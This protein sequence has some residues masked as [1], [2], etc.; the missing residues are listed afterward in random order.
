METCKIS[1][2]HDHEWVIDLSR[3]LEEDLESHQN[4][5]SFS[6]Y[7]DHDD[8]LAS[9]VSIFNV[10]KALLSCKPE[11]YTPQVIA[12]GPYHHRRLELFE[13][14]RCKITSAKKVQKNMKPGTKFQD[15]VHQISTNDVHTR[16]CYHR[17]L[18]FDQE[19]L[20]WLF[21]I[22]ASFLLEYLQTFCSYSSD[23]YKIDNE[24]STASTRS[25]VMGRHLM[26][27]DY[28][29]RRTVHQEILRDVIMLEN[30]IPLFLIREVHGFFDQQDNIRVHELVL[31]TILMGFCKYISPIKYLEDQNFKQECLTKSHLL[32]LLYDYIV[33]PELQFPQEIIDQEQKEKDT[34]NKEDNEEVTCW[35]ASAIYAIIKLIWLI[36]WAPVHFIIKICKSK[37]AM[38]LITLPLKVL[39]TFFKFRGK[40][41]LT[42]LASSA[43][44]VVEEVENST[45]SVANPEES[46][47]VEELAI[48]S[49]RELSKIGVKFRPTKGGLSTIQFKKSSGI[50]H[51][52]VIHVNDNSDVV[53]RNL[54][55]YEASAAPEAMVFTRYT[56]LMNG[57]IDTEEDVRILREA[58]VLINRMKSDKE[59]ASLWN[60]MTKSVRVTKVPI[61]DRAIKSANEYYLTSWKVKMKAAMKKYVYGSWPWLTFLAANVFLCLTTVEA[62]CS[63][64]QCSKFL[65]VF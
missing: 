41:A 54:V 33:V 31:V 16:A 40:T 61:L 52:P 23:I 18:D 48:P 10:P 21:S 28:T 29:R 27:I 38:L 44:N 42:N 12:L 13:M 58:G 8:E 11:V 45:D 14:E 32:D 15:L 37:V 39:V 20:A 7:D 4:S 25:S 57:I 1:F 2:N 5:S 17:Y 24:G 51:L 34:D 63:V 3:N 6:D 64:Y 36:N 55:A 56:E 47:L 22:D 50:F 53:L 43:E 49:V 60:G 65:H 59:V 26:M 35:F 19:T 46:P 62:A 9:T 30:Q